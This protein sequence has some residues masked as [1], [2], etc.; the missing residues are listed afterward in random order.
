MDEKQLEEALRRYASE[1]AELPV[2]PAITALCRR[3]QQGLMAR[4][5]QESAAPRSP[6]ANHPDGT[7]DRNEEI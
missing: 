3:V 6:N 5:I 7:P 1:L 2:S 4:H